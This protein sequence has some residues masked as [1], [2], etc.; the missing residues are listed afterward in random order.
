MEREYELAAGSARAPVPGVDRSRTASPRSLRKAD[1]KS[2][3]AEAE[4]A[5]ERT[6]SA[7]LGGWS[8]N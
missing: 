7:V 2:K 4:S 6:G 1:R 8:S 3:E 5:A